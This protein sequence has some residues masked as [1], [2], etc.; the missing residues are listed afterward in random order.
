MDASSI[1]NILKIS[2]IIIPSRDDSVV[3]FTVKIARWPFQVPTFRDT[4]H[5]MEIIMFLSFKN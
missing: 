1:Q 2:H 4:S 3:T 5:L